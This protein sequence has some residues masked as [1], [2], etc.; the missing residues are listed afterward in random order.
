MDGID[1]RRASVR[2]D[3]ARYVTSEPQ[4]TGWGQPS[5]SHYVFV[6]EGKRLFGRPIAGVYLPDSGMAPFDED[7]AAELEAWDAA[8]D[9]ALTKYESMLD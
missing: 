2:E 4:D 8:S 7:L 6:I 9:E 3:A 1:S 5:A